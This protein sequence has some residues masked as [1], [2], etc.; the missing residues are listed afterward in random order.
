MRTKPL[1][2]GIITL[3]QV[4]HGAT[5][6][7]DDDRPD[8]TGVATN[9]ATA[10]H[11]IQAA[12]DLAGDGDTVLVA[13]GAYLH[14]GRIEPGYALFNRVYIDEGV[15]V[16]GVDGWTVTGIIG[17]PGT[18]GVCFDHNDAVLDGFT[19]TIGGTLSAGDYIHD[20]CGGGAWASDA[21]GATIK[22]CYISVNTAAAA[23]GGVYYGN[24]EDST[25]VD[26]TSASQ[27]GGADGANLV[28]CTLM[29]N[30][31]GF[32]PGGGAMFSTLTG[33]D[34]YTNSAASGGGIYGGSATNCTIRNNHA[35]S[36]SGGGAYEAI[37]ARCHVRNNSSQADGGGI[38]NSICTDSLITGN[39]AHGDG[40]DGGGAS[41][42]TLTGCTVYGNRAAFNGGTSAFPVENSII[43]GNQATVQWPNAGFSPLYNSCAPIILQDM[44]GNT[45]ANP[46]FANATLGDFSLQ[47]NSPCINTG[48]NGFVTTDKDLPGRP[49][50]VFGTVDMG[51]YERV[52]SPTDYD[53]DGMDNQAESAAD[54]DPGDPDSRLAIVDCIPTNGVTVTW[55][56]GQQARQVVE[57]R[58]D[59][60]SSTEQWAPVYTNQPVTPITNTLTRLADHNATAVRVRID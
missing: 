6:Y 43:Y 18:R 19:I 31:S 9:W 29:G 37:L 47:T 8:D 48:G 1:W 28:R 15:T 13:A 57:V 51:A 56:G 46:M 26:N 5:W 60:A 35:T 44:G 10:K 14:G 27:G 20:R 2:V 45:T 49:R 23:G 3:A 58:Q 39:I 41:G 52:H 12:V 36:G 30:S 25:I 33:C 16:R 17:G 22:N 53:G 55:I 54:T 21:P 42:G 24:V 59:L 11:T 34:V 38:H 40:S 4:A 7:V 50:V 32:G